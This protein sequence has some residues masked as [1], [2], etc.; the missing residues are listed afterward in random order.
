MEDEEYGA[1]VSTFG[2]LAVCSISLVCIASLVEVAAF[3]ADRVK[4]AGS[5]GFPLAE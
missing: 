4:S 5:A 3:D 2:W 1:E